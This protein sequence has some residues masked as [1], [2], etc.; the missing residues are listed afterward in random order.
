MW[1]EESEKWFEITNG[2]VLFF[3]INWIPFIILILIF[4]IAFWLWE[5]EKKLDKV[6]KKFKEEED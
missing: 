6:E 2:K 3:G 5:G 4:L 1:A